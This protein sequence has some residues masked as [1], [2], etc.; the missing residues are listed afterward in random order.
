MRVCALC[1]ARVCA[2][3]FLFRFELRG[4]GPYFLYKSLKNISAKK[5][6]NCVFPYMKR[7]KKL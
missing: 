1:L 6:Q 2:N 3:G 7:Q 5:F 4:K